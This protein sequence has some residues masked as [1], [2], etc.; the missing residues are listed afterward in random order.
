[1]SGIARVLLTMGYNVSGSDLKDS[2][3]TRALAKMGA[4]VYRGHSRQNIGAAQ[5]VVTSSA[6]AEANP[7]YLE[8]VDNNIPVITRGEMLAELMRLKYGLAVAGTHGKTTTTALT[9]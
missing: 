5:V 7:E 3:L 6:I 9:A 1:M 8:A 4:S 2:E